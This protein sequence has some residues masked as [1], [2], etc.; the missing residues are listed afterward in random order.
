MM[1]CEWKNN[2]M[3]TLWDTSCGE[4]FLLSEGTPLENGMRYCCYCGGKLYEKQGG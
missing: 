1:G 4:T 2:G 3:D